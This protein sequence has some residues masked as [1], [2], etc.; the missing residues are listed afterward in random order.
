MAAAEAVEMMNNVKHF[1]ILKYKHKCISHKK[2][3]Q[4]YTFYNKN[5]E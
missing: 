4:L 3:S 2:M 1:Q 5:F